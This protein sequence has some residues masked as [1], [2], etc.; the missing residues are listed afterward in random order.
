MR[1]PGRNGLSTLGQ[2]TGTQER[3]GT[4][5]RADG[6]QRFADAAGSARRRGRLPTHHRRPARHRGLLWSGTRRNHRPGKLYIPVRGRVRHTLR[7]CDPYGKRR[8]W[9]VPG[10]RAAA[11]G[12]FPK[13][14]IPRLLPSIWRAGAAPSAAGLAKTMLKD[15]RQVVTFILYSSLPLWNRTQLQNS[16]PRRLNHDIL[17]VNLDI[18]GTVRQAPFSSRVRRFVWK[19]VRI[20]EN[21]SKNAVHFGP[22]RRYFR[23]RA[24]NGPERNDETSP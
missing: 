20:N 5:R 24:S 15:C 3:S 4:G 9:Q 2:R 19:E 21:H 8:H 14:L 18:N 13:L 1:C 16:N 17:N 7:R 22:H 23:L 12:R 11:V 6:V 10:A